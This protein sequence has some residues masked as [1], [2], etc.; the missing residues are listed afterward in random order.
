MS[1]N[2][3]TVTIEGIE[4]IDINTATDATA[5]QCKYLSKPKFINSAVREPIILM[6]QHFVNSTTPNNYI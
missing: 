2:S 5:I 1:T 6:L 4:D 3:D